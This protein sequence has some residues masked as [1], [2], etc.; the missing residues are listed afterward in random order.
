MN[1]NF[2][3]TTIVTISLAIL[4]YLATYRNDI[5]IMNRKEKLE[6]INR[7][8]KEL[9]GPLYGI[10]S[11]NTEVWNKFRGGFR[12]G[13][14]ATGPDMSQKEKEIWIAWMKTVFVPMNNKIYDTIINNTD[15][16]IENKFP[17]PLGEFCAHEESYRLVISKWE[18]G[19]YSDLSAIIDY[20]TSITT[21]VD[22]SYNSLKKSQVELLNSY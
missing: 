6:R 5:K 10:T 8:L 4:S 22:S 17:K 19:D 18:K 11:A 7:Q 13:K 14:P 2:I 3:I 20:P 15:L 1:K 16:I 21:Y 12:P 9:Y